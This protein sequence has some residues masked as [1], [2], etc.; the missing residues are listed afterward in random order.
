MQDTKL[1]DIKRRSH[2]VKMQDMKIQDLKCW[3]RK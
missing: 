3:T 2:G 1:Q